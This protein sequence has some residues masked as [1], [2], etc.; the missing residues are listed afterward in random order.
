VI[1]ERNSG[2]NGSRGD[3]TLGSE[4][5]LE[6][7]RGDSVRSK[8]DGSARNEVPCKVLCQNIACLMLAMY[9]LGIEPMLANAK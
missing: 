9:E 3:V 4:L 8:S 6:E 5:R 2:K 1:Q 7:R